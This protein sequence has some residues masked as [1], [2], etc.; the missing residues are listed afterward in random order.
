MWVIHLQTLSREDVP[1]CRPV[2]RYGVLRIVGTLR[3]RIP[4]TSFGVF[5]SCQIF[6]FRGKS[7]AKNHISVHVGPK[8]SSENFREEEDCDLLASRREEKRRLDL[9][10][11]GPGLVC[12]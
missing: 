3:L 11:T 6:S 2:P 5:S 7:L 1:A 8:K 9:K 10:R 12:C 4:T